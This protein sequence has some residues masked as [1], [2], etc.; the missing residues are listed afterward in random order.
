MSILIRSLLPAAFAS[1]EIVGW[2]HVRILKE[3][4]VI[5]SY[6]SLGAP[7]FLVCRDNILF[8]RVCPF[9]LFMNN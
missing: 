1:L 3:N 9:T 8:D 6:L 5:M 2:L 4:R 7:L